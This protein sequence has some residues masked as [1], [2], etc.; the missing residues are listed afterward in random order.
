MQPS[1]QQKIIAVNSQLGNPNIAKQQGST[2]EIYDKVLLSTAQ[3]KY[4]L[5]SETTN[6]VFPFTNFN[7]QLTAQESMALRRIYL[8]LESFDTTNSLWSDSRALDLATDAGFAQGELEIFVSNS[9]VIKTLPIKSFFPE[10]NKSAYNDNGS[11][12]TFDSIQVLPPLLDFKVQ[13]RF[14]D[15]FFTAV[16]ETDVYLQVGLS[17]AGGIFNPQA[18]Y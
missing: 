6:K 4:D 11:V 13:L 17:G 1:P 7:N 9:R 16:A 18:N 10:F 14:P 2:I 15:N 12:F 3:N 8:S 5:F